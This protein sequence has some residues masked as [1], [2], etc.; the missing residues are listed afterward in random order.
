[1]DHRQVWATCYPGCLNS[2]MAR[3]NHCDPEASSEAD[4]ALELLRALVALK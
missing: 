4:D 3:A 2:P 1:M